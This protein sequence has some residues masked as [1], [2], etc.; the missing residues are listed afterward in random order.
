[1]YRVHV[2]ASYDD[3]KP[4]PLLFALHGGGGSMDYQADDTK[5]GLITKSEQAG[6]V[7]VFPNGANL[8]RQMNVDHQRIYATGMS[9]GGLM[10]YQLACEMGA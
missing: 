5:Y 8:T 7:A 10:S 4:V 3:A 1:M 9:N 6:F 2:P